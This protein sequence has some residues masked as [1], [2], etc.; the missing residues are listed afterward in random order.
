MSRRGFYKKSSSHTVW[1][2]QQ[3]S[4]PYSRSE[5]SVRTYAGQV[6]SRELWETHD[7][8]DADFF[9]KDFQFL[10]RGVRK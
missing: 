9:L 3:N 1:S 8:S 5:Y 2:G 10:V 6:P 7:E 4:L